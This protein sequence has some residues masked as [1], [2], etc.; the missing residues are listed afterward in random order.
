MVP[1]LIFEIV[2]FIRICYCCNIWYKGSLSLVFVNG[3]CKKKRSQRKKQLAIPFNENLWKMFRS[4]IIILHQVNVFFVLSSMENASSFYGLY[5]IV[6][7]P[8]F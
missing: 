8:L 7:H 5:E 3:L 1:F 6:L 2:I 4:G